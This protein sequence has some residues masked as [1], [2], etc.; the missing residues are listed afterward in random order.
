M[1]RYQH[2]LFRSIQGKSFFS[3]GPF[4]NGFTFGNRTI[5]GSLTNKV[6]CRLHSC[7][8][9]LGCPGL[10]GKKV[11]Y[12]V[13]VVTRMGGFEVQEPGVGQGDCKLAQECLFT[14]AESSHQSGVT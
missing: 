14:I 13:P 6:D 10:Q 2:S 3:H 8:R 1:D 12:I 4:L 11:V 7:D 9:R 5:E